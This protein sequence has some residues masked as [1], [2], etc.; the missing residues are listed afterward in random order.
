MQSKNFVGYFVLSILPAVLFAANSSGEIA[1]V[2]GLKADFSKVPGVVIVHSPADSGKY[3]GS[4]STAILP[5]GD[6]VASHDFFGPG[7]KRGRWKESGIYRSTD[8]GRSWK[9]ICKLTAPPA[10]WSNLFWHNGALYL[11]GCD[12]KMG[13]AVIRRSDDYGY[14]WTTPSDAN[15]G[16]LL[17]GS[18]HTAPVPMVIH[19]GRIWRAME[20]GERHHVFMMSAP[21]DADLLKRSN[22]TFSNRLQFS[23]SYRQ[24]LKS[25]REAN[26][27][28]TPEGKMAMLMR[29][30]INRVHSTAAW[31]DVSD[32]GRQVT[33][34]PA[35]GFVTMPGATGK[36][37]TIRYD[38]TS[39]CYWASVNPILTRD[40]KHMADHRA[41]EL[42]NCLA[43]SSSPDLKNWAV[44][45][46]VA[47][48][49][50]HHR[51]AFQYPD[52]VFEGSDMLIVSRT[53]C[54]DALGGAPNHHDANFMTF[55]R[56]QNFRDLINLNVYGEN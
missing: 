44:H 27:V 31:F 42:R 24:G 50:D 9:H 39:R 3:V 29:V 53:A 46:V 28:V 25:W 32:D 48:H 40:L 10:W 34:D 26:A 22:W 15:T 52:F 20:Q 23:N 55:H 49:P 12:G 18:Y 47:Y 16:L 38:K 36:K 1:V 21:V 6:Y 17:P 41:N 19:K 45:K 33:F 51:H 37:F 54:D 43:L 11:C 7:G 13:S 30:A 5:N 56:V 35:T 8:R 4:P 14:T 2:S